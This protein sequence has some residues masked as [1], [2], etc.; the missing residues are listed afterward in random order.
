MKRLSICLT[1]VLTTSVLWGADWLQ[2]RGPNGASVSR[3]SAPPTSWSKTKNLAWTKDLPGMAACGPIVVKGRVILTSS[4]IEKRNQLYVLCFDADSGDELWRRQFWATGRTLTHPFSAVAAPTPAS[5]GERIFAFYSS[6]DLICLDL[7]GNLLWYRGLAFDFPKTG[8]DIGMASSPVVAGDTVVVQL[9]NQG[10]SFAAGIDTATGETR[11]RIDRDHSANWASPIAL[12]G[13]R[14]GRDVVLLQGRSA[15][16]AYDAKTGEE[17]W[18]Y[19][20]PC[21][22]TPSVAVSEDKIFVPANGLT[23]LNLPPTA[24][25]PSMAWESSQ[26]NPSPAS[27]IIAG[28]RVYTVNSSGVV[29]CGDVK[30]GKRLWQQRVGGRH[31]STPVV[32]GNHMYCI[33][34]DGAVKVLDIAAK[35]KILS[36]NDFGEPIKGSPAIVDGALFVRSDRHLWKIAKTP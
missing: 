4:G 35:G 20:L 9:E 24:S 17:L 31:W 5:D 6:N 32:A 21:S 28:D 8:N 11:W 22:T 25:V 34:S 10:D 33:N 36:K 27:P 23:V 14:D 15:L 2:F 19:E 18:K 12:P 26:L 29:T 1:I 7:D 3:D 30:D 16:S 13:K